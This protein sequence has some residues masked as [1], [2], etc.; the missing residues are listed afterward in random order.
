VIPST[1]TAERITKESQVVL[2]PPPPPKISKPP[3][4]QNV[5]RNVDPKTNDMKSSTSNTNG[6]PLEMATRVATHSPKQR[7][8]ST[9]VITTNQVSLFC[10]IFYFVYSRLV[11]GTIIE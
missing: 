1:S 3:Q 11:T 7:P 4:Q 8:T 5:V 10:K 9:E 6:K 2:P